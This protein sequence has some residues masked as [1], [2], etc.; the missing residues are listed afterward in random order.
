MK[1]PS[2]LLT[3]L[4]G[5][6][7]TAEIAPTRTDLA[8][9]PPPVQVLDLYVPER[10]GPHPLAVAIHGGGFI[11]GTKAACEPDLVADLVRQGV[12]V[13]SIAYRLGSEANYPAP[14][15]DAA[16]A[17]QFLRA[18]AAE[19]GIDP[20]RVAAY[21]MSAGGGMSLWLATHPDLADPHAEDPILRQSTRLIA[22]VG[23]DAQSTYDP[24][25]HRA[26]LA[27]GF[28]D[29]AM[30]ALFGLTSAADLDDP[31]QWPRFEAASPINHISGDDPPILMA[32]DVAN[33]PIDQIQDHDHLA[34]HPMFGTAMRAK[35]LFVGGKV[36]VLY[37]EDVPEPFRANYRQR[38]V[39]FLLH[40]LRE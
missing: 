28:V 20:A 25:L 15:H 8:Y 7:H 30:E 27:E 6:V 5:A 35:A 22:A 12:M 18:S 9:G 4:L 31:V 11:A 2:I 40:H 29:P 32:Y 17:V 14:M 33:L 23:L 36:S 1:L 38:I 34:H 39:D 26:F 19:F 16:R 10:A 13:A 21:G 3:G 37:R 24:R